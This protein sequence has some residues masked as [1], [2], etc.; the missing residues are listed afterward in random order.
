MRCLTMSVVYVYGIKICANVDIYS[1]FQNNLQLLDE[2]QFSQT[3]E[4]LGIED[5]H[6]ILIESKSKI[7]QVMNTRYSFQQHNN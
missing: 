2:D 7:V 1:L 6:P 5:K 4:A 3:L